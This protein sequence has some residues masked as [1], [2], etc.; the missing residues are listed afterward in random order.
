[1]TATKAY[2]VSYDTTAEAYFDIEERAETYVKEVLHRQICFAAMHGKTRLVQLLPMYL[3]KKSVVKLL[4]DES[5]YVVETFGR[6]LIV[7]W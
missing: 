6:L 3:R 1:M 4:E 5:A 2:D 7:K